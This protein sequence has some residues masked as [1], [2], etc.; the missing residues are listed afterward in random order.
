MTTGNR[1]Q[2][3]GYREQEEIAKIAEIA[4]IAKIESRALAEIYR[5][6][7]SRLAETQGKG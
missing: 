3:T 5:S 4:G 7:A 2:V 1:E 6:R